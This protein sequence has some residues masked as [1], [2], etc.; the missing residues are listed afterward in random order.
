MFVNVARRKSKYFSLYRN[1]LH[2]ALNINDNA[3]NYHFLIQKENALE[4]EWEAALP[5]NRIPGPNLFEIIR[6]FMRKGKANALNAVDTKRNGNNYISFTRAGKWSGLDLIGVF[7]VFRDEYGPIVRVPGTLG[8]RD[9]VFSFDPKDYER[10]YRTEGQWPLRRG[11]F[12]TL[13]HY[14][15]HERPDVFKNVG[16][17]VTDQGESWAAMRF[18]VNPVM[19]QPK[20]VKTYIPQVDAISKEFVEQIYMSRDAAYELPATFGQELNKWA[21]ESIGFIALDRRLGAL[22]ADS[23]V[24]KEMIKNMKEFLKLSYQLDMQPSVWR[25]YKTPPFK[26]LMQVFDNITKYGRLI[27]FMMILRF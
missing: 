15:K 4:A 9:A 21:L 26:R 19:L 10:V 18:K 27:L 6:N 25:Y 12:E 17:L 3:N 22:D 13:A 1:I 7:R 2:S 11:G 14:R 24:G 16:G 5:Y 8:R 20:T 23:L